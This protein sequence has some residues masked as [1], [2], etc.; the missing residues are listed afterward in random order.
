MSQDNPP[1]PASDAPEPSPKPAKKGRRDLKIVA[2]ILVLLILLVAL[3][4]TIAG[5][6]FVRGIVV[7]KIN[8]NLDGKLEVDDWSLGWTSGV[9]M[10][11][12]RL[13]DDRG[14]KVAVIDK[15][16]TQ[17]SL[18]GALRGKYDLGKTNIDGCEF[19]VR[20]DKEGQSNVSRLPKKKHAPK[21]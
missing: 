13:L 14:E 12:V 18:I 4:P 11:G 9:V 2:V 7:G 8:Q 16:S 19:W 3:L 20:L 6:G 1:T 5:L 21:E 17:L 10:R 15:V